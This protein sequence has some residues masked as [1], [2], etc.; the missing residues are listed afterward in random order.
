MTPDQI[1]SLAA[2]L[3]DNE[4]FQATLTRQRSNALELLATMKRDNEM[5][6]YAAQAIVLVIDEI[7][8]DLEQFIRS[9][10]APKPPGLA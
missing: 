6:F 7:R 5:G 2:S 10:K 4:A 1:A 3:K 8:G 9:G